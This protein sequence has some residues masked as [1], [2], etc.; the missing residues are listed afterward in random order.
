MRPVHPTR[1]C[2][3]ERSRCRRLLM[4]ARPCRPGVVLLALA[5][6]AVLSTAPPVGAQ[7]PAE[8]RE[9]QDLRNEYLS[10]VANATR[11]VTEQYLQALQ[12]HERELGLSG[13]YEE[14]MRAAERQEQ[15]RQQ[16]RNM[17]AGAAEAPGNKI[18]LLPADARI[19]GATSHD[20]R[21]K[22]LSSW[23]SVGSSATWEVLR[24]EPGIYEVRML[25]SVGESTRERSRF[26]FEVNE[27]NNRTGGTLEFREV[28]NLPGGLDN[29]VNFTVE[30]TGGWNAY[31]M[32]TLG[33]F[34][35][36]RTSASFRIEATDTRGGPVFNLKGIELVPVTGR[37]DNGNGLD[38][39][40]SSLSSPTSEPEELTQLRRSHRQR[41]DNAVAPLVDNYRSALASLEQRF[42]NAE[43]LVAAQISRNEAIHPLRRIGLSPLPG[44]QEDDLPA[45]QRRLLPGGFEV[46][47]GARF[48]DHPDNRIDAFHVEHDG[49]RFQVRLYFVTGPHPDPEDE[50]AN[51]EVAEYFGISTADAENLALTALNFLGHCLQ[52]HDFAVATQWV[53]DDQGRYFAR[54]MLPD[55]GSL[56]RA[57]V[58]RGLV[59][60]RGRVMESAHMPAE[61]YVNSVLK[62][63][64]QTAR[65]GRH[66]GWG[67]RENLDDAFRDANQ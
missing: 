54:V 12:R 21:E 15:L 6:S 25:Y 23:R 44:Q 41:I 3:A 32:V 22:I 58:S 31:E 33:T 10:K 59:A 27:S 34:N 52:Q 50:D 65:A 9:L 30:S 36:Q 4:G 20:S 66:G 57:L 61:D 17:E 11:T 16:R 19:S 37:E 5:L 40:E 46:L 62:E 42:I 7:M 67:L 28:T 35:L 26:G 13:N 39:A 48:I 43:N 29:K 56:E 38:A 51:R 1:H 63:A 53:A 64:E 8:P 18:T 49:Q 47:E 14:A 45:G 60:I 2:P 24:L 55:L